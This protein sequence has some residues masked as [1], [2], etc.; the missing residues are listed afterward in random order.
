[1]TR[2]LVHFL[3]A[4]AV[5]QT[6]SLSCNGATPQSVS[7][8]KIGGCHIEQGGAYNALAEIAQ[9]AHLV[10]G[11]DAVQPKEEPTIVFD[12][13]GGTVA[14]LLNLFV[15]Q[16]PDYGWEETSGGIIH[17]VRAGAHVSLLDVKM[18]YPGAVRKT[19]HEIWADLAQRPELSAWMKSA[20]CSR[21]EFLQGREFK[22]NNAPISIPAG[23][24]TLEQLLDQVALGSGA[25]YWA[26]LQSPQSSDSCHVA[27][28]LW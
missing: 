21:Q 26:V 22:D 8:K 4:F 20:H 14:D 17:A 12:F 3:L 1:M 23:N 10:V 19:R 28:I 15:S 27:I 16:A 2:R 18:S 25:N 13:P 24:L 7:N 6:V 5:V 11:V 9:K